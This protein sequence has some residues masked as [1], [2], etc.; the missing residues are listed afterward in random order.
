MNEHIFQSLIDNIMQHYGIP[1]E[2]IFTDAKDYKSKEPRQLFF[3][4]CHKK[5]I[6]VVS[7]QNF[8]LE[9]NFSLHHSN[10]IRGVKRMNGK[11]QSNP[12]YDGI[13]R[14]LETIKKYA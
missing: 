3:Y 8:L 1:M 7:I 4:L 13:I 10:I 9:N 14:K 11:I 12:H 2:E 5:G 6:P